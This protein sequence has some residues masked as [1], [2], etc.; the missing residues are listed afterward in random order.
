MSLNYFCTNQVPIPS[1]LPVNIETLPSPDYVTHTNMLAESVK[2]IS[3]SIPSMLLTITI[4]ILLLILL[5]KVITCFYNN[6]LGKAE[7]IKIGKIELK[8]RKT[9]FDCKHVTQVDSAGTTI[10]INSFM[11]ILDMIMTVKIERI[12]A[13]SVALSNEIHVIEVQYDLRVQDIFSKMFSIVESELQDRLVQLACESTNIDII[14]IKNTREYFFIQFLLR[15]YEKV[16][17]EQAKEITRR[18]GFVEFLE[19]KS[20]A[21]NYICELNNSIYQCLDMG[22]LES[23]DIKK[24]DID[25]VVQECNEKHYLIMEKMFLNLAGIKKSMLI[26]RKDKLDFIDH[27]I[28]DITKNILQDIYDK[29]LTTGSYVRDSNVI[30]VPSLNDLK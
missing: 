21:K 11:N 1:D 8:N 12:S 26:K 30:D 10:D 18:N 14:K 24:S 4:I 6:T 16:W 29:I 15:E 23:T 9:N 28:K 13:N 25:R 22:N 20:K 2:I 27:D 3:K 5:I 17:N 7:T 19:D